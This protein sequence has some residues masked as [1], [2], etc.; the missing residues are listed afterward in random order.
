MKHTTLIVVLCVLCTLTLTAKVGIT[1]K[2]TT[3]NF[4]NIEPGK[5][6]DAN[7]E[8]KNTGD[9]L[10]KIS[11]IKTSCGCTTAALAKR[12][13]KPGE[14]GMIPVQFNTTNYGGPVTKTVQVQTNA[15]QT[16]V[17]LTLT[18][19][20]IMKDFAQGE[21]KPDRIVFGKVKLGP[22][23]QQ[24]VTVSNSGTVE[25]RFFDLMTPA[26]VS[27]DFDKPAVPAGKSMELTLK[28]KP[29]VKGPYNNLFRIRTNDLRNPYVMVRIEA[30]V[31]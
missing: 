6:V 9:E 17:M 1:F 13:Y 10:L 7:Y 29:F 8:F 15:D 12:E 30:E 19:T 24:K 22:V 25:L 3:I 20:V 27:A 23:Y 21:I 31:E 14:E 2:A 26:E 11:D 28:F 5:M 4:G 18:G 16:P